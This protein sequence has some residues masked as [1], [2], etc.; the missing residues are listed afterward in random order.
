[1]LTQPAQIKVLVADDNALSA[2]LMCDHL[3]SL[4]YSVDR[5][6]DGKQAL[7]KAS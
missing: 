4:G 7:D 6:A 1:V 2:E 3:Q 5:A